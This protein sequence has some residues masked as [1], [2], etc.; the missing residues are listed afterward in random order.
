MADPTMAVVYS[1]VLP[2][3]INNSVKTITHCAATSIFAP[4]TMKFY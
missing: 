3:I 4:F 1:G 2:L